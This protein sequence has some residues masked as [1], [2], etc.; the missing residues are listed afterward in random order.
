MDV[1]S[2][3][4]GT[5]EG[6]QRLYQCT[7][8]HVIFFLS[9]YL[10]FPALLHIRQIGLF[11]MIARLPDNILHSLA[12]YSLIH[13]PDNAK[14]WFMLIKKLCF[15]Y[16]LPN[17]LLLLQNPPEKVNFKKEVKSKVLDYWQRKYREDAL[18]LS[19]L[20]YFKPEFM[21]LSTPHPVW[22][23]CG[24][25]VYEVNKACIQAKFLSGRFRTDKLLSHFSPQNSKFC[26]LHPDQPEAGDLEHHLVLCPVLAERRTLLFQYWNRLSESNTLC[27]EILTKMQTSTT[28]ILMQFLLD[29]SVMPDVIS[30]QQE[31]GDQ[32][33]RILFKATRT[34]CYSMY[35]ERLKR[36]DM[37]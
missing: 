26:Q 12:E 22:T 35:R 11:A 34:Y 4:K 15:Q 7:H 2:C 20:V 18:K 19:S 36:L 37:W 31:H 17:P 23:T 6:L 14:S 24:S 33:L 3:S 10:P 1:K 13:L 29:C 8:E 5:L 32:I 25:S 27:S 21:S 9:G 30:L 16:N 28:D